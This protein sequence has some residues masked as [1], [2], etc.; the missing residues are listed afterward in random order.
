MT[1]NKHFLFSY[2]TLQLEKVQ[3]ENYG[4]LLKGNKDRLMNYKLG[5]LKITDPDVIKKSG[6]N[7]HP[8]AIRTE[9]Q[10]DFIEG[11]IY[12]LTNEELKASDDYEV[13][14]YERVLEVFSSKQEAWI[15]VAKR[16]K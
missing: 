8:I 2:G 10:N 1:K 3:I 7:Y 12:E 15:Y 11:T 13:N 16:D 14:E 4:R 5:Q 6:K 9:N